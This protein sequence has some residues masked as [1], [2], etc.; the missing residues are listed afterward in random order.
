MSVNSD[1]H[2]MAIRDFEA[3]LDEIA[4]RLL[5]R[6]ESFKEVAKWLGWNV[7]ILRH[8]WNS[9]GQLKQGRK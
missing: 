5:K 3:N 2:K 9:A 6:G 1:L 7:C 4:E 8:W